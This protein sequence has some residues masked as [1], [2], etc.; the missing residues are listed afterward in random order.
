VNLPIGS[1]TSLS[2][3]GKAVVAV[4]LRLQS[5]RIALSPPLGEANLPS[6][7]HLAKPTFLDP[8]SAK[9]TN[10]HPS[11]E[12]RRGPS[13]FEAKASES[14]VGARLRL[15]TWCRKGLK[16]RSEISTTMP[17]PENQRSKNLDRHDH[18]TEIRDKRIL[19]VRLRDP[20][21]LTVQ[22]GQGDRPE[23]APVAFSEILSHLEHRT[24]Y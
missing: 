10:T 22:S 23:T 2:V 12:N 18:R 21:V 20:T 19:T 14:P 15:I 9:P 24:M 17:K 1:D 8:L 11:M 13:K 7:H 3:I 5:L 6:D 4:T 16:V